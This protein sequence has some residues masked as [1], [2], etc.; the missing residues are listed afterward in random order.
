[1]S[2]SWSN[3][4][5]SIAELQFLG[6]L[7][8]ALSYKVSSGI[9]PENCRPLNRAFGV[10]SFDPNN[11]GW[12]FKLCLLFRF[13]GGG[14]TTLRKFFPPVSRV[15]YAVWLFFALFSTVNDLLV[16]LSLWHL[17]MQE[18]FSGS[19]ILPFVRRTK[20]E[21]DTSRQHFNRFVPELPPAVIQMRRVS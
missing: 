10:S 14:S 13:F 18:H 1:L 21:P 7:Q 6:Q 9:A 5:D 16:F 15:L 4:V 20:A 17:R 2:Y 8:T 11:E 3:G 19:R 12:F